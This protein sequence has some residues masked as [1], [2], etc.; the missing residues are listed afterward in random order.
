MDVP[1]VLDSS[2]MPPVARPEPRV[3]DAG[4]GASWWAEGWRLFTPAVGTW[5]LILIVFGVL[6]VVL[7]L[8]PFLGSLALQI[9]GPVFSG[10]VML[11]CR[12]IDRGEPL[13]LGH[14]FAGFSTRAS[15]LVIVGLI[16]TLIA[17]ACVVVIFGLVFLLFGATVLAQLFSMQDPVNAAASLSGLVFA[18]LVAALFFLLLFMPLAMSIWFAPAL[19][20]LRGEEPVTAMK[21]SFVGCLRNVIPFLIYGLIGIVLAIV[22]SIPLG[23]GWLV[24]APMTAA[25]IYTSYCDIFE[26]TPVTRPPAPVTAV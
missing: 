13:R 9:L 7:S 24:V 19:V 4:R 12:A 6:A 8:I 20:V 16:Y 25:S 15:S 2:S 11:G 21:L 3:V 17:I 14:L 22:A 5:I 18:F 23:L 10:G 26:A 1:P